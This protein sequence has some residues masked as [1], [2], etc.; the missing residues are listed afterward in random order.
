MQN[1]N[2]IYSNRV[3][4]YQK[5]SLKCSKVANLL[6]NI[7]LLI[8]IATIALGITFNYL[9]L[10]YI[11]AAISLAGLV[12]FVFAVI[13]HL[14]II[15]LRDHACVLKEINEDCL[16]RLNGQWKDFRDEGQEFINNEHPFSQD[17]DVFGKASLFQMIN[18]SQTFFGRNKLARFLTT[19]PSEHH[20]ICSRQ[21]AGIEL[22]KMLKWRQRLI[23]QGILHNNCRKD[24]EML[25][26]WA[27][28]DNEGYD[29]HLV[30]IGVFLLPAITIICGLLYLFLKLIP[31]YIP[32]LLI[33][34]QI[35]ILRYRSKGRKEAFTTA[36]H[37]LDAVKAYEKMLYLIENKKFKN[38]LLKTRQR[39]LKNSFGSMPSK[40]L[41]VLTKALD[42]ASNR[43]NLFFFIF[44]SLTLW[45]YHSMI[46]L[47]AWKKRSGN[48]LRKWLDII[49]EFEVLACFAGQ[50]FDHPQWGYPT[51]SESNLQI[52][53]ENVGH[54]LLG[55]EFVKNSLLMGKTSRVVLITGSNMSG[56]S[57]FLR[58]IGINLVMA[59]AGLPVCADYFKCSIMN[60]YTCMRVS[61]NL[62]KSISSFYA[63]LL[64][65]KMIVQAV[66]QEKKV[67]FLLDE[68]F[69]GTNSVDRQTGATTLIKKLVTSNSIGMVSTHD[70]ELGALENEQEGIVNSHF[71]EYY[72]NEGI[73][74][75]YKLREGVSSTR[76]AIYLMRLVGLDL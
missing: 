22:S 6:S 74:F 65:I 4:R 10:Y 15:E 2:D 63:E 76:N 52:T 16:E 62:E 57:T 12:T 3:N 21:N 9:K 49:A 70:L 60:I 8:V 39:E 64:R 18:T 53:A 23:S 19:D 47:C 26:Q 72:N 35:L 54:P 29:T 69:K 38:E 42:M 36:D 51:F 67:F 11:L 7:R 73:Q 55:S 20:H 50:H 45:E 27:E 46:A 58:T 31:V 68:I 33:L 37:Y 5:F 71:R 40:Q 61:D 75:D 59:Y 1:T 43:F 34:I 24:P 28:K 41:A 66:S 56:K 25:L 32:I 14:K 44:N 48:E 13:K 30:K 17:L